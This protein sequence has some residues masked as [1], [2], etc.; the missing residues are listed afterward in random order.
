[1]ASLG[2]NTLLISEVN[3]NYPIFF[4]KRF[5]EWYK[6]TKINRFVE[7]NSLYLHNKIASKNETK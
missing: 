6:Y 2:F 7:Y 5:F 4:R 1:M 3:V